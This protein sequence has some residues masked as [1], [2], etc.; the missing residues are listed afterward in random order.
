M[1]KVI[2]TP[3]FRDID[4]VNAIY[5]YSI[6]ERTKR[7]HYLCVCIALTLLSVGA[8]GLG[9]ISLR[10]TLIDF[11]AIFGLIAVIFMYFVIDSFAC[12]NRVHKEKLAKLTKLTV[13]EITDKQITID[14]SGFHHTIK[15]DPM[16][17]EV[18][19]EAKEV[20]VLK[21]SKTTEKVCYSIVQQ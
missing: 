2:T 4:E 19:K 14:D 15:I 21:V 16:T 3:L 18:L 10:T 8:F 11:G 1:N 6:M 13:V 5:L 17:A 20:T 9:A 7:F 12:E